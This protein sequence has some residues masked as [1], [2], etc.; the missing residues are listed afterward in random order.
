MVLN[1]RHATMI[2]INPIAG[3]IW[4]MI[5]KSRLTYIYLKV[6]AHLVDSMR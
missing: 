3:N 5:Y 2:F 6:C 4:Y 1:D